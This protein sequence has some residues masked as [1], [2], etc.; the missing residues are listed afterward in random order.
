M[1]TLLLSSFS[2]RVL[3]ISE[4]TFDAEVAFFNPKRSRQKSPIAGFSL[5]KDH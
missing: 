3:A 5:G 2:S 1:E 4:A